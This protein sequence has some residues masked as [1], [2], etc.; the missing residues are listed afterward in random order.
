[1][2][3]TH[4]AAL[5]ALLYIIPSLA[6]AQ[7]VQS[8]DDIKNWT[9]TGTN[10]SALVLQWN[11]GANPVSLVWGFRWNDNATGMDMLRAIGGTT[12][13]REPGGGAE[14]ETLTGADSAL[15]FTMERYGFGDAVYSM[16]Y[17]PGGPVRTQADWSSGYWEYSLFGGN[18]SY[19]DWTLG[20]NATYNINGD[21]SYSAVVWWSSQVGASDRPLVDSSWDALSFA[22]GFASTPVVQPVAAAVPEPGVVALLVLAALAVLA[23][24]RTRRAV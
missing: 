20:T 14:I 9:G 8:F 15:V 18:L 6:S 23:V 3:K 19:Y 5:T 13:V 17:N 7:L 21:P 16:V 2:T 10:R 1:M 12:V 24:R 4:V 11:D 22:A